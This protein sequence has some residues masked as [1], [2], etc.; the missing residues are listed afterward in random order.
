MSGSV[1][2]IDDSEDMHTL[3][4]V[5]L[6][7]EGIEALHAFN[8]AEG[9]ALA[10]DAR[11]DVILL[12][13]DLGA[14][15]GLDVCRVLKADP[16]TE[17][18]PVIFLTGTGDSPV[19]FKAFD[20]GAIDYVVKPFQ[21][22]DLRARVRTA[23]RLKRF[24][25]L[26]AERGIDADTELGTRAALNRELGKA[27]LVHVRIDLAALRKNR[28]FPFAERALRLVADIVRAQTKAAFRYSADTIATCA[29]PDT[30][31]RLRT[32][33]SGLTLKAGTERVPVLVWVT[34]A[35]QREPT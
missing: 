28:G 22:L 10:R 16:A 29:E 9:L 35:S 1:L 30:A 12:D 2:V 4:E 24:R 23:L 34:D 17:Q 7:Q 21:A 33:T 14:E 31:E 18:I 15:S 25:D 8:S 26:L 11:P 20:L 13:L 3:V 6:N 19:K 32:V 5:R 27:E